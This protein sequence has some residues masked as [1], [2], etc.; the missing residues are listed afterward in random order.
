M[1]FVLDCPNCGSREVT[2]FGFGG[3]VTTRPTGRPEFKELNRYVYFR[4]NK[5]GV[6]REWWVHR[7]G[8]GEWFLAERDTRTNEVIWTARPADAPPARAAAASEGAPR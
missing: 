7:A 8:C 2:D 5:A 4:D 1:S 3:E 6:Q